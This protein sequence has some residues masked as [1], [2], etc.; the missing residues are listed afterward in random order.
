[1]RVLL[2][3]PWARA[4]SRIYA[5]ELVRTGH[6]VCLVT[7]TWH[8]ERQAPRAY[9]LLTPGSL[10]RPGNWRR[11][12]AVVA[13]ARRFRPD[14]VVAEEFGDPTLIPLLS[15]AP[16]ATIVHDGELHDSTHR[17]PLRERLVQRRVAAR[18]DLVISFSECVAERVRPLVDPAMPVVT[19]PLPS[20]AGEQEIPPFVPAEHRRDMVLIGRISPY[21]NLDGTFEAWAAHVRSDAYRDD[22]LLV[23]GDGEHAGPLPP[24]CEWR[25]G[26]FQFGDL[27]PVL[28]GA[29]ASLAYY[30]TGSQSGV[31]VLSMQCGTTVLV[32]DAGGLAEYLPP[33]ERALP[34]ADPGL[35]AAALGEVADPRTAALRG[36]TA[37]AHYRSRFRQDTA[38]S[39]LVDALRPLADRSATSVRS[40]EKS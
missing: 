37:R 24:A 17:K 21:K 9:E 10:R 22:R 40:Q 14:V 20:E 25:R 35:L 33:G 8:F 29:K 28:A 38:V 36:A 1:M 27:L 26:R 16:I 7:T 4:L 19:V 23:I 15:I 2:V 32:S 18:T 5:D 13:E 34:R 30:A 6:Q 11:S 12:A 39:A 31:Q 3:T